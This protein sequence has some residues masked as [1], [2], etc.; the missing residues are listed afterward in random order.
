MHEPFSAS[1]I[2]ALIAIISLGILII[3]RINGN[4]KKKRAAPVMLQTATVI[5][6]TPIHAVKFDS[7]QEK[8][9]RYL[10]IPAPSLSAESFLVQFIDD[11][12]SLLSQRASK[13]MRPASL[14]KILTS[15]LAIEELDENSRVVF[16]SFA[17][18]TGE[19]E[20]PVPVGEVFVRNDAVRF[21]IIESANDAAAALAEAIGRKRGAFSFD[22]AMSLFV[23]AANQKTKDLGMMDSQF[24]NPTGFDADGHVTSAQDLF[25]LVSYAWKNHPEIWDFSRASEADISS[26]AHTVYHIT[27]TNQL[28]N[29]FPALLGGKTGLT[30]KAK[31]TLILLYPAKLDRVAVI[32]ILG[33]DDRFEDG[34]KLIQ[35]LEEG[36]SD[37][38]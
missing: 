4:E 21:V 1:R 25:R 36:F 22:D 30:D 26:L 2:I 13:Q 5:E 6:R 33:S 14:T 35:W 3:A 11:K 16:S 38:K 34:K 32:I 7:V 27:A 28:L 37:K 18:A 10:S 8:H 31:G 23:Q 20:S 15:V 29:Q 9:P 24:Q 19:K 17:K 12:D